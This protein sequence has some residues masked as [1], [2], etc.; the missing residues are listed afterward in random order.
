MAQVKK[1]SKK[2]QFFHN[3]IQVI[4]WTIIDMALKKVYTKGL[5]G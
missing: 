1:H 2:N 4:D 3:I 5:I